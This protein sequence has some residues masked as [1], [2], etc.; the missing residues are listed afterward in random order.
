[1]FKQITGKGKRPRY[2]STFPLVMKFAFAMLLSAALQASAAS[3]YAQNITINEKNAPLEKIL[4]LIRVQS[5]YDFMYDKDLI[6][7]IDKVDLQVKNVTVQQ[8]MQRCLAGLPLSFYIDDRMIVIKK[9]EAAPQQKM[10]ST[11]TGRVTDDESG[12]AVPGASVMVKGGSARAVTDQDGHFRIAAPDGAVVVISFIG[13]EKKEA[14]VNGRELSVKI[15]PTASAMK[16]VVVTGYGETRR[17]DLTGSIASV[18]MEDFHK[19]PVRSF[20]EALAGRVAGV[21]VSSSDGQPG[22]DMRVVIRGN[23]SVTQDNSPLYVIDG[24]PMESPDNN[25]INPSEIT[26]IEILKDAS[27]TAIYGARGA[28]GVVIITTKKGR[29]GPP[30]IT[31]NGYYGIQ[32]NI[33]KMDLMEPYEF[34]KYQVERD[35]ALANPAY[36]AN[37]KS[38]EEYRNVKGLDLQDEIFRIQ[39]MQNHFISISGGTKATKYLISGSYLNQDGVIVNTGYDRFQGRLNVETAISDNFKVGINANLSHLDKFGTTPATGRGSVFSS[40]LMYSVWGFRPVTGNSG[41]AL[42]DEE[43]DDV[44]DPLSDYRF[45]PLY[46]VKNEHRQTLSDITMVNGFAEYK[47]GKYLTL[48]VTGGMTKE[49]IKTEAFNNSKTATGSPF[50]QAGKNFGVN[51]SVN[52]VERNSYLN[53]NTLTFNKE[54]NRSHRI[55]AVAGFTAQS[56]NSARNGY[57]A[58]QVPNEALGVAGLREGTP[59]TV[60]SGASSFTLASFLGRVNY[61]F[62]DKYLLTASFRADGSSKFS[63]GNKWGFFPSGSVAWRINE[64]AFMKSLRFISNAKLRASYGVTGNNRVSDFAYLSA[65]TLP[66]GIA[67]SFDNLPVK[68]AILSELGTKMLKWESTRQSNIGLDLGFF[69]Q[70]L[71]LEADAYKKMTSDLL[72]NAKLPTSMGFTEAFKNIGKVQNSGLEFTLNGDILRKTALK[73]NAGFNISF[74]KN[75]LVQLADN[76]TELL[77][78]LTWNLDFSKVPLYIAE[79]GAPIS[80]YYGYIW[81]GNY[82]YSD[83]DETSPG[84]YAL[85]DGVATY[86]TNRAQTQPGDIRLKDITG[87]GKVNTDDRTVIGNPNPD[88]TGGFTNNFSWKGFD[89]NVFFQFAV[90]QEIF[91]ANRIIFEGGGRMHQNMFATYENRW[92]PENQ[93]NTYYRTNG[94]GPADFGYSTRLVEDGSYLRLKTVALGYNIPAGVL[95]RIKLSSLRVYASAQNLVT[96]TKYSGFDPEVSAFD[97]ALTPGFDYSVYPRA[98]TITF[99]LNMTL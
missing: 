78:I 99:G 40:N 23:N 15:S 63:D 88:Y 25:A 7:K 45:N 35:S 82:Q 2:A 92:T 80:Q 9:K 57:A 34:V 83:F 54:L 44:V 74:N 49:K 4:K 84:V 98:R 38:I 55:N 97:S 41:S 81:E 52:F 79:V 75:K 1:M 61:T 77:S 67:Y 59:V 3:G 33:R 58:N 85:K 96:W 5:G 64:E 68:A 21:Q 48:R 32:Q 86:R 65:I 36:L 24:F 31:Y 62:R 43:I 20:E 14:V 42:I 91:N 8:A 50:T 22:A 47:I 51:G 95:K 28:N 53:E 60:N 37:G 17:R 89:L 46:S 18:K 30:V 94:Q 27:A 76:Q 70:R 13:Y 72:L 87:D 93:N 10:D 90:G 73:W 56:S 69:D 66:A 71:T 39:P 11:I 19:A 16:E 6:S 29:E 26:S 12:E